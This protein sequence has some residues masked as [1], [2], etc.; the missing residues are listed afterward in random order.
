[1]HQGQDAAFSLVV[2]PH[3]QNQVFEGDDEDERPRDQGQD[4]IDMAGVELGG[5]FSV[6][7][8]AQCVEGAGADIAVDYA[9]SGDDDEGGF[10]FFFGLGHVIGPGRIK[11]HRSGNRIPY[12]IPDE[13]STI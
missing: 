3:D 6:E 12:R 10:L 11:R 9:E 5:V 1:M 8:Y 7:A 4:A 2:G 13:R